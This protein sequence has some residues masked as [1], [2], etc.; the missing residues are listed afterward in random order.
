MNYEYLL[1]KLIT[2]QNRVDRNKKHLDQVADNS[3]NGETYGARSRNFD[4]L[5]SVG[6]FAVLDELNRLFDEILQLLNG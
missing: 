3:H 1:G 2:K 6:F 4:V 5:F